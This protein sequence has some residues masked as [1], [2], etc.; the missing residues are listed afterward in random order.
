MQ[1]EKQ[2]TEKLYIKI[3]V[4]A[5]FKDRFSLCN[6]EADFDRHEKNGFSSLISNYI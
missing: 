3:Y 1:N 4:D 6:K 5:L 2:Q